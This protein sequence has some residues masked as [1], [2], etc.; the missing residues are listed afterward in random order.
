MSAASDY[1]ENEV[2]DHILGGAGGAWTAPT[3]IYIALFTASTGL[4]ANNPTSEVSGGA[5]ARKDVTSGFS[6]ASGGAT[7]NSAE[8]AFTQATA[9]WGTVSHAAIVDHASN[10]TWGTN[11]NVLIWAALDTAKAV[12]NGDTFKFAAGD[13][14]ITM[15]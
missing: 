3:N 2:L 15:A 4:E 6:A 5:Y 12:A 1:L 14:D 11:V 8:Q 13:F 10:T 9:S 7:S